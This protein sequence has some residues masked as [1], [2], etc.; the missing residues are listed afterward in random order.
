LSPE[1]WRCRGEHRDCSTVALRCVGR[2]MK[3]K[4][5]LLDEEVTQFQE[6]YKKEFGEE[7]ERHDARDRFTKLVRLME[8]IYKPMTQKEYDDVQKH[9][10]ELRKDIDKDNKK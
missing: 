8:I 9:I 3:E 1:Q 5:Y 7:L 2:N 10:K 4:M 6:L